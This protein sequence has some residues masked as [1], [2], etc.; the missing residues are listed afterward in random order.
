MFWM[1]NCVSDL[2]Y[3]MGICGCV[4]GVRSSSLCWI[5]SRKI[6]SV[7]IQEMVNN[8]RFG[9][10]YEFVKNQNRGIEGRTERAYWVQTSGSIQCL[11]S[12]V[13][14]EIGSGTG[15]ELTLNR[16]NEKC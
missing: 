2:L 9:I 1:C 11:I 14:N 16:E 5:L 7:L 10:E 12:F 8:D 13:R 4:L 3:T 6:C 15:T